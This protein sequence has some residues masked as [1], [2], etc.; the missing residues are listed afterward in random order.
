[1]ASACFHCRTGAAGSRHKARV[2]LLACFEEPVSQETL[3]TPVSVTVSWT[4]PG[5]VQE[6]DSTETRVTVNG[7]SPTLVKTPWFFTCA[8][9]CVA[10]VM[11]GCPGGLLIGGACMELSRS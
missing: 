10:C 7:T 2:C 4:E 3:Q 8:K 11:I 1:M 9:E 5:A 6:F